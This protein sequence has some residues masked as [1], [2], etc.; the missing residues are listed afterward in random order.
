M[1]A[2]WSLVEE[3]AIAWT[4]R[5][6][7]ADFDDWDVLTRWLEAD[8]THAA[9]FQRLSSLDDMLPDLFPAPRHEA[10]VRPSRWPVSRIGAIAAAFIAVIT[11]S[12]FTAQ[13]SNYSV[14][15]APGERRA[16]ALEDGS[17][18]ELNGDTKVTLSKANIRHAVL[19]HGEALFTVVH[20]ERA[21]FIVKVGDA[22]V[23]DAGTVFN[24]IR[25]GGRTEVGV[26]EGLVIYNPKREEVALKPGHGLRVVGLGKAPETFTL[27]V[28][29]VGSWQRY[30]LTY[31]DD[32]ME[33]VAA[34]LT[35]SL[36]KKIAVSRQIRATRFTGTINLKM[37]AELFLSEAA[38]VLG[39]RAKRTRDGWI[40]VEGDGAGR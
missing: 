22:V 9:A 23:Q 25:D 31:N 6:R 13:P 32:T 3:Q 30:Q 24:I 34:D 11:F 4:I 33:R 27:P 21:P 35:R 18:I 36:G 26:S 28:A 7:G 39:V 1:S 19:D 15:T 38:P 14:E 12:V 20:N 37:D 2:I 8:A 5:A 17:R 40:L 10:I 29:A 16:I